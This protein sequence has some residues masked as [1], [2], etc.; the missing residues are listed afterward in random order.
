[1]LYLLLLSLVLHLHHLVSLDSLVAQHIY[2]G[3]SIACLLVT[4]LNV[5]LLD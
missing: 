4:S 2:Y 5:C 3:R 1:M